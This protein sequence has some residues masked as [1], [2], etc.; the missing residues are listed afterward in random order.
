MSDEE[1]EIGLNRFVFLRPWW[2]ARAARHLPVGCESESV[3][4]LSRAA[5]TVEPAVVA[6]EV[7]RSRQLAPGLG[8]ELDLEPSAWGSISTPKRRMDP[9]AS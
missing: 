8:V 3:G 9:A 2:T 7:R 4:K 1:P 6:A 5:T